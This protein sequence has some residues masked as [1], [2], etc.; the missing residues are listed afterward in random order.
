MEEGEKPLLTVEVQDNMGGWRVEQTWP[1][2]DIQA[3]Q[4][5]ANEL[6]VI[7]GGDVV[8]STSQLVL[9]VPAFDTEIL[10]AGMPTFHLS[11][12]PLSTLNGHLFIEMQDAETEMHLG[13]AV[14][15]LRFHAGGK[16]GSTLLP[17]NDVTAMMEFFPMDVVIPAG[18]GIRLIITQTGED[19]IPS[20]ACLGPVSLDLSE[21]SILTLPII[22]RTPEDYFKAS[23]HDY[24]GSDGTRSY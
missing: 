2:H 11:A 20:V 7:S 17:F 13:H 4:F 18:H 14:M 1:P 3:T 19:Y 5:S 16:E 22:D 23:G 9:E 6:E 21:S 10:I 24:S 12:T 15:D 8:S